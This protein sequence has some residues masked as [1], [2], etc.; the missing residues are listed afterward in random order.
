M[1]RKLKTKIPAVKDLVSDRIVRRRDQQMKEKGKMYADKSRTAKASDIKVGDK[2]LLKQEKSNKLSTNFNPRPYT[3][4]QIDGNSI[5]I[6][7]ENETL[8]RNS[9]LM[10]KY[11]S[12]DPRYSNNNQCS[13][14]PNGKAGSDRRNNSKPSAG[15]DNGSRG[16]KYSSANKN[17]SDR[18]CASNPSSVNMYPNTTTQMNGTRTKRTR[19]KPV[20]FRDYY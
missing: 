4:I 8:R 2:V 1:N 20:K 14:K 13:S 6:Q 12:N 19:Y 5:T 16:A 11:Y 9:S 15:Y 17:N 7:N 3:V 10:K 18:I